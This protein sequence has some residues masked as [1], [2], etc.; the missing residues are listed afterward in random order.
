MPIW[1]IVFFPPFGER[2]SPYDYILAL[3]DTR[4]KAQIWHR[5]STLRGLE[6]GDW[7]HRW[8]HKITAD[9]WQLTAGN[10]RI[11]YCLADRTIVVLH[12]FRK[13]GQK[14]LRKDIER[15]EIHYKEYLSR[16]KGG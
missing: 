3:S 2:H 12:A 5:L 15:A 16:M 13:M 11:M 6:I 10:L 4:E 14:T 8:V 1:N 7:P 9:I